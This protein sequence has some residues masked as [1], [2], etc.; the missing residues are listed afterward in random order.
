METAYLALGANLGDRAKTLC[1]AINALNQAGRVSACSSFYDTRPEGGRPQPR[2]LNAALRLQTRLGPRALLDLCLRIEWT[3][4]RRRA[5]GEV[6]ADRPIDIDVLLY[7]NRCLRG[8]RL[9]VPHPRLLERPFVRIPLAEVAEPGLRHPVSGERLDRSTP[10]AGVSA[11]EDPGGAVP[12]LRVDCAR[13]APVRPDGEWVLYWMTSAHRTRFNFALDRALDWA[14]ALGKPLLVVECLRA[15]Y[16]FASERLHAFYL[17]GMADNARR[18]ARAG[19]A[20]HPF[21]APRPGAEQGLVPALL[22]R[23]CVAVV[24]EFPSFIQ[25]ALVAEVA[26]GSPVRVEQVDGNGLVPLRAVEQ[27][28]T[29]ALS[30]RRWLQANLAHHLQSGPAPDPLRGLRLPRLA[31]LPDDVTLGWPPA[32]AALLS[33]EPSA[34]AQLPIDHWVGPGP[35]RGGSQAGQR[36]RRAVVARLRGYAENRNH[37]DRDAGSGLSP[38][39]HFGHISTHE[40]L[41][42][43]AEPAGWSPAQLGRPRRGSRHGFWGLGADAEAFL[44]QLV[45]WRELGFN[46]CAHRADARRY[47]SLPEWARHTLEQHASDPR[48]RLYSLPE[49]E[50]ARTADPLWNAAQRQL[51]RE[52]RLHNY[53]RMLWGKRIL[54]W[55]RDPQ[56]ALDIM[57]ELNDRYA[58]DGRDPNSASG[59][60][61]VLGRYDHPWPARPIFGSVRAMSSTRTA[62]KVEVRDYL[63]KYGEAPAR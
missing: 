50:A 24:D 48:E 27:V 61:W 17:Q 18:F 57:F 7:G 35:L 45:T 39:L 51:V 42:A 33:A 29:S 25:P 44:D 36:R 46:F 21:V 37:P 11:F 59:I 14:R 32:S 9:T 54:E 28:F 30:F 58:L 53:L 52:G 26:P 60:M 43:L 63:R 5:P 13:A 22:G 4:G 49:L 34:L 56:R 19:V 3:L 8:P 12:G 62:R 15:D 38:Y 40:V 6:N 23:A 10:D 31:R 47:S 1:A 41:H 2:Y 16:P 55:S 20:H